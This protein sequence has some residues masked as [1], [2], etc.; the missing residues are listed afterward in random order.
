M[1]VKELQ[2][3]NDLVVFG[4]IF[5]HLQRRYKTAEY[6][7]NAQELD[8]EYYLLRSGEKTL[9]PLFMKVYEDNDESVLGTYADLLGIIYNKFGDKWGRLWNAFNLNY[10]PI[11]N[12]N[13]EEV[14]N[15]ASK[16]T[17]QT[18]QNAEVY[19]FNS[20]DAVPSAETGATST[21]TGNANDNERKLTRKG[22]I[23]VTTS[24]QMLQSEFELRKNNFY[25]IMYTDIDTL[26]TLSIY[27]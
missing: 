10:N 13:S 18:T 11:E 12:Y 8:F 6:L 2:T 7:E 24:Q 14:E 19:G 5:Q 27:D 3:I 16:I 15:V 17:N 26:L 4:G 21:T 23:G 20:S 25:N 22:N 9:S 1:K